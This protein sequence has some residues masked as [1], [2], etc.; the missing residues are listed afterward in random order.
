MVREKKWSKVIRCVRNHPAGWGWSEE[1]RGPLTSAN[2]ALPGSASEPRGESRGA[3]PA[4]ISAPLSSNREGCVS[5]PKSGATTELI[6][7]MREMN[8]RG[9]RHRS[10]VLLDG[11]ALFL[12]QQCL[13][14]HAD[15]AKATHQKTAH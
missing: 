10:S 4:E 14:G 9:K 8:R 1:Q 5:E 15:H 2:P 11:S 12:S 3:A 6:H 13:H 7:Q